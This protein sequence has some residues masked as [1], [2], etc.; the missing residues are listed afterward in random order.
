M[1]T[2][3]ICLEPIW[4]G[5]RLMTCRCKA[6]Y[7][8]KCY[9]RAYLKYGCPTCRNKTDVN[10]VIRGIGAG[11]YLCLAHMT[12]TFGR[13]NNVNIVYILYQIIICMCMEDILT[14]SHSIINI[15][16]CSKN[17]LGMLL[18]PLNV[19]LAYVNMYE[20]YKCL[21]ILVN[22]IDI[23]KLISNVLLYHP[24]VG[25]YYNGHT[26]FTVGREWP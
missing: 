11:L 19:Y 20:R 9:I 3:P 24:A 22:V 26:V 12:H 4:V 25:T 16:Q 15:R 14:N 13:V 7:H 1:S 2:C 5:V 8:I 10:Y 6:L 17:Q 18:S 23:R 21:Y